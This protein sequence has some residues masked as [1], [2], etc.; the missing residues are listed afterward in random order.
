VHTRGRVADE[1]LDKLER[2]TN[3]LDAVQK[4]SKKALQE[5][6]RAKRTTEKAKRV[7]RIT[8]N[9]DYTKR[10]RTRTRHR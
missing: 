3:E 10:K 1:V 9:P 7:I 8:Q 6:K 2:L 4:A 5:V